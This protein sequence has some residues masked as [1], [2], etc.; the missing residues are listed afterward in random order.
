MVTGNFRKICDYN[1]NKEDCQSY[2][3]H[4][5]LFFTANDVADPQKKESYSL[6][7][8]WDRNVLIIQRTHSTCK[9]R[10]ENV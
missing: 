10:V 8:L 1:N 9:A 5:E 2:I 3:E 7:I 4:L 6:N